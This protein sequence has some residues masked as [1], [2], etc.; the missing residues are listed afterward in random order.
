MADKI[1]IGNKGNFAKGGGL[2]IQMNDFAYIARELRK[3]DP[4]LVSRFRANAKEIARPVN[5]EIKA[6]IPRSAPIKGMK[7]AVEPGRLTWNNRLSARNTTIKVNTKIRKRGKNNSI[8]SVWT[9]SAATQMADLANKGGR[10]DGK[11][12]REYP[13]NQYVPGTGKYVR[14]MRRH[15]VNGQGKAM[16]EKLQSGPRGIRGNTSR[17]VWAGAEKA[18]PQ[19]NMEF[20]R[21]IRIT[22]A[23]INAN[24]RA[25]SK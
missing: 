11:K 21:L 16:V 8:V 14:K 15:R 20:I 1:D 6:A 22:E 10:M 2:Y 18:I 9:N 19:V 12:T 23:Q 4:K 24:L 5:K 7:K 13:Y 3:I 17:M 25:G